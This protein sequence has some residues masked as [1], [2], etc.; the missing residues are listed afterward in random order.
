[1]AE[2]PQAAEGFG[3]RELPSLDAL[4]AALTAEQAPMEE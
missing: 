3:R 1:M 2:T 4:N